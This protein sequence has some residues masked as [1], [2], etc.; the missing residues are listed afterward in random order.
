M[1]NNECAR[2]W[3]LVIFVLGATATFYLF[4]LLSDRHGYL[5]VQSLEADIEELRT[6]NERLTREIIYLQDNKK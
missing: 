4:L 2:N 1:L 5:S 6:E 3:G